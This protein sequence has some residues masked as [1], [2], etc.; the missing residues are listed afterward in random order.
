MKI[1]NWNCNGAFREDF[2]E[3]IDEKS[4]TYVDADIFVIQECE[5]P[6]KKV[7]KDRDEYS[8]FEEYKI[9]AGKKEKNSSYRNRKRNSKN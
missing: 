2:K 8:E 3:I 5:D 6:E 1:F 4:D 9:W 7:D